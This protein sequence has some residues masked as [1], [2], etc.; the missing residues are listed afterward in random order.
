[1]YDIVVL[2]S[3]FRRRIGI[4]TSLL[5]DWVVA[6]G[7]SGGSGFAVSP[8]RK[9]QPRQGE[10]SLLALMGSCSGSVNVVSCDGISFDVRLGACFSFEPR[11]FVLEATFS[12]AALFAL[13]NAPGPSGAIL[14]ELAETSILVVEAATGKDLLDPLRVRDR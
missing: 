9:N 8:L 1:M 7:G 14:G 6:V 10:V 12:I 2:G 13:D 3:E 4:S 5:A 11:R